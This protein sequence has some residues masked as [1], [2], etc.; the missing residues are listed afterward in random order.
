MRIV[1][2]RYRQV[3][4]ALLPML[5]GMTTTTHIVT[6]MLVFKSIQLRMGCRLKCGESEEARC[7]LVETG[8]IGT[9]KNVSGF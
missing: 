4:D 2:V 5:D 7:Q 1:C 9:Y 3:L 6:V 8:Q